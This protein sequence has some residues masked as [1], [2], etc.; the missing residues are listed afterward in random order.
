MGQCVT[1]QDGTLVN[2]DGDP[3][4]TGYDVW[5]YNYQGHMFNGTYCDAYRDAGWCQAWK[6]VELMMKWNDAWLS[7][8]DCG[9]H[10]TTGGLPDGLLDRYF[11][12]ASYRGSGAWLTNHQSG[13]YFN[14][15]N[16][17][18]RWTYFV[19]IVAIPGDADFACLE[20][21]NQG[22][23]VLQMVYDGAGD[24]IGERIWGSFAVVQRV[25][26]DPCDD[27]PN[28]LVYKGIRPGVGNWE[29]P[30]WPL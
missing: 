8:Q 11:G 10:G 2:S 13:T 26:N 28:G 1:I 20:Y 3:I 16:R 24:E 17:R 18:C 22:N 21:D 7:N 9:T 5:G 19:K 6:D 12:H 29:D 30:D 25:S 27:L 15:Q 23:C 14:D 4:E